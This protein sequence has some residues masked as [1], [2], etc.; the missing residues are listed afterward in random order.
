MPLQKLTLENLRNLSSGVVAGAFDRELERVMEDCFDRPALK[1]ARKLTLSFSVV[2]VTDDGKVCQFANVE[3]KVA[4]SLPPQK[5]IPF[6]MQATPRGLL[7]NPA[8]PDDARQATL[9]DLP[10]PGNG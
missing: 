9:N 7:V 2:P 6:Q 10:K 1:V 4:A 8:S 5:S 3:I